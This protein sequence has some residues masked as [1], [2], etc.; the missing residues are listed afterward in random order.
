MAW[1]GM[2]S[3]ASCA[4]VG[5]M[6]VA[7]LVLSGVLV[8]GFASAQ[9][10]LLRKQVLGDQ[11]AEPNE[12]HDRAEPRR[13]R[14][15]PRRIIVLPVRERVIYRDRPEPPPPPEPPAAEPEPEPEI[16]EPLDPTGSARRLRARGAAPHARYAAGDVLPAGVPHVTLDARRYGL[17]DPPSGQIYARVSGAVYLIDAG[18][19]RIA[20]IVQ[21]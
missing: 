21:N 3:A 2:G 15:R 9:E 18:T 6:K 13:D 12:A 19:R 11:T 7:V 1:P 10:I 17:P 8:A 16:F 14:D 20:A 5:G 4:I